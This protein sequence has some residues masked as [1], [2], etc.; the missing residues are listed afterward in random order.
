[1]DDA[2]SPANPTRCDR[3]HAPECA[4][5]DMAVAQSA[6]TA[7]AGTAAEAGRYEV[8]CEYAL[9]NLGKISIA[10]DS[11]L[12]RQVALK[13][14]LPQ[15]MK[16]P[17][18]CA[19]FLRE[20]EI[21]GGLEHPGIVPVYGSGAFPDGRP[22]YAMR[23]IQGENLQDAIRRFHTGRPQLDPTH[24]SLELRQ[25]L[26]RF[27]GICNAIAFAHSRGVVH[28]DL[29]PANVMLGPYGETLIIDWGLAKAN[30]SD[31]AQPHDDGA[32]HELPLANKEMGATAAGAAL[33]TP[34]YMS[35]E[36]AWGEVE[37]IGPATD[38]FGLGAILYELLSGK[39]PLAGFSLEETLDRAQRSQ[40]PSPRQS[41]GRIPRPLE[42]VC[43][44]AMAPSPE[45]RYD[46]AQAM[47]KDIERWLADEPVSVHRDG[48][49]IR[50]GR[51]ARRR[52][53]FV[54]GIAGLLAASVVALAVAT[55]V[56]NHQ[57]QQATEAQAQAEQNF[58]LGLEVVEELVSL[59]DQQLIN[60]TEVSDTR[61][62]LLSRAIGFVRHFRDRRTQDPAM[63]AEVAQCARRLANLYRLRGTFARATAFYTEAI[64]LLDDVV[65]R[66]PS[67]RD[68]SDLR[69]ETLMD[70]GES[71]RMSGRTKVADDL[72]RRAHKVTEKL[73]KESSPVSKYRRTWARS[74]YR[75]ASA[76]PSLGSHDALAQAQQAVDQF[77]A[78]ADASLST[79]RSEVLA[80]RTLPLSDQIELVYAR[81]VLAECCRRQGDR[82]RA[83]RELQKA[84][85]RMDQLLAQFENIAIDDIAYFH[86]DAALHLADLQLD[87]HGAVA[88]GELAGRL[89]TAIRRLSDIVNR[90]PK[91]RHYRATLA[92]AHDI[93]ARFH[94]QS[95]HLDL[96]RLDAE[97][98]QALLQGLLA[99]YPEIPDHQSD[100]AT[101]LETLGRLDLAR[102]D[103][104]QARGRF[105]EAITLQQRALESA[106]AHP[107]YQERLAKHRAAAD[108]VK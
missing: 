12:N 15:H 92:M 108:Q 35:P 95:G 64:H 40:I 85:N 65:Q 52:R 32:R 43:M 28:R 58:R 96:A 63:Q 3:E 31:D 72:F 102:G 20:A 68:F 18:V 91:I 30:G 29:K 41:N 44:K 7:S 98:S 1:M 100:L 46:S 60:P 50:L 14:M 9:G 47:A 103:Q 99:L 8:Q 82:P 59:G 73:V 57:K 25:L 62:Q 13:E 53:T 87:A 56:V 33:G 80:G 105:R 11:Q 54:A 5:I 16:K 75:L 84:V 21:T 51:W 69:A 10:H 74:L 88:T 61:E 42:A 90:S 104:E 55:A 37:K 17:S 39:A 93:R 79:A 38:I 26:S 2:Q 71:A 86:A 34:Q 83:E 77:E 19:R 101:A 48:A 45:N 89:D 23:L 6:S 70:F 66:S 36:Q 49:A 67:N 76:G 4:T 107:L 22:F 78:L 106:P 27:I 81:T 97:T 94:E 24:E